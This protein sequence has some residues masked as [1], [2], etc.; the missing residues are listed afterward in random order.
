LIELYGSQGCSSCPPAEDWMNGLRRYPGLWSDFVP[1]AFHITYWDSLGWR[2]PLG[3]PA[4]DARER[5]YAAAWGADGV[6]TPCAVLDGA[7]WKGWGGA[8]PPPGPE[9]G[10]LTARVAGTR[11]RAEFRPA[12]ERGPFTLFA[13]PLGLGHET[14]VR[15]GENAGRTLRSDFAAR[16]LA[17]ATMTLRDG[18][19]RGSLTLPA[20]PGRAPGGDAL[21]VWV[22]DAAGRPVQAAGAPRR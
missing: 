4:Y 2:D 1:V 18:V 13:A 16:G 14:K 8:A 17:R 6:Y 22:Q 19:W 3:D 5:A 7:E 11:V 12:G 21:A 9:A 20:G 15:A 10:T